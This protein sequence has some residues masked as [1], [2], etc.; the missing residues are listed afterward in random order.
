[1][2]AIAGGVVGGVGGLAII[3]AL[4]LFLLRRQRKKR[5]DAKGPKELE[6]PPEY[7]SKDPLVHTRTP[8]GGPGELEETSPDP[9]L[10][11]NTHPRF[12][13]GRVKEL[14]GQQ[15]QNTIE[16]EGGDTTQEY[17]RG[18]PVRVPAGGVWEL[19]S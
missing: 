17:H 1:M 10:K 13:G 14:Q 18:Q 6:A 3:V 12:W 4:V 8:N 7:G 16:L 9:H 15:P 11:E 19:Q 5:E 2:G